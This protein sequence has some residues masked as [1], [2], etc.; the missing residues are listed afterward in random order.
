MKWKIEKC[1][2]LHFHW[3]TKELVKKL[4]DYFSSNQHWKIHTGLSLV[5][6]ACYQW[7]PSFVG[8][9]YGSNESALFRASPI[10]HKK[11]ATGP[12]PASLELCEVPLWQRPHPYQTG[13]KSQ[14]VS[15]PIRGLGRKRRGRDGNVPDTGEGGCNSSLREFFLDSLNMSLSWGCGV[16]SSKDITHSYWLGRG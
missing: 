9:Q 11:E 6:D 13:F 15:S 3:P 8:E 2:C 14:I 5:R 7:S 1:T 16:W 12:S 10:N 4:C